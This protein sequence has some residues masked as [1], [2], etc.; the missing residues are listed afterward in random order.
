VKMSLCTNEENTRF[1]SGRILRGCQG[2]RFREN[3]DRVTLELGLSRLADG[4]CLAN[5]ELRPG[6]W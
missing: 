3:E 2:G 6:N 1:M 5:V 4:L